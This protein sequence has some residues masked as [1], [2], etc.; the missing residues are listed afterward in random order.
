MNRSLNEHPQ[1]GERTISV[2][3]PRLIADLKDAAQ[4]L[5]RVARTFEHAL[6]N[7][8]EH[9]G[10]GRP[11]PA[12]VSDRL[13]TKQLGAIHAVA[14]RAGLGKDGLARELE[15]LTGSPDPAVLSRSEAS[16]AIEHLDR[17]ADAAH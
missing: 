4:A 9:R 6:G 16:A 12:S 15:R 10:N 13:T 14:R 5:L 7:G 2:D 17:L 11:A 3:A 1:S 8:Q